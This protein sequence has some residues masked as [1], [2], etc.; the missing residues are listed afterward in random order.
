M[1]INN[2][3]QYTIVYKWNRK[4]AIC[5]KYFVLLAFLYHFALQMTELNVSRMVKFGM[6]AF[7]SF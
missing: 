6:F 3:D 5:D 2:A 4:T 1:T 7:Y